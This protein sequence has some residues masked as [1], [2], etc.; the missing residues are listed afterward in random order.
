MVFFEKIHACALTKLRGGG[1]ACLFAARKIHRLEIRRYGEVRANTLCEWFKE[2]LHLIYCI[3][4]LFCSGIPKEMLNIQEIILDRYRY[5]LFYDELL[6]TYIL[7]L[8]LDDLPVLLHW[9][10]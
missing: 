6:T 4:S 2:Y 7:L 1:L 8:Y 9:F 5:H 3:P 10:F